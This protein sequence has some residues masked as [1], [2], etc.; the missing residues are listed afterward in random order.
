MNTKPRRME[1]FEKAFDTV[2]KVKLTTSPAPR[3]P[4]SDLKQ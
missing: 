3:T 4:G 1:R 2:L